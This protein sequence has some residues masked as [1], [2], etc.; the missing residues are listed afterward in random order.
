MPSK[1]AEQALVDIRDNA[2]LAQE[3]MAGMTLDAFKA[4]RRTFYAV[5]RCLETVSEASRRL[6]ASL[7]ERHSAL[8]WRAIMGLGNV[9]RHNYDNGA[10]DYVWRTVQHSLGPLL[11]V[12]EEEIAHLPDRTQ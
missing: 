9:Y 3:F 12:I 8:P 2:R 4:D 10:E 11:A 7:R 5:A 6:P 1:R